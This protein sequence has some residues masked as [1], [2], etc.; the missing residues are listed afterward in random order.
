M[1]RCCTREPTSLSAAVTAA[2]GKRRDAVG[3][4]ISDGLAEVLTE[5]AQVRS[6]VDLV[7]I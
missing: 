6:D 4:T 7:H 2:D 5:Y 3:A 1:E